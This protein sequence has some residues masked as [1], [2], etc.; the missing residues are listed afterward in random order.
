M[1]N[2]QDA[3]IF[4]YAKHSIFL[5]TGPE[6]LSGSTRLKAGSSQK[7]VLNMISTGVMV[8][9]GKVYDN[10]MVDVQATNTKLVKRAAR[11]VMLITKASQEQAEEAL[12]QSKL[13]VK[14]ACLLILKNLNYQE[15]DKLL[16]EQCGSLRKAINHD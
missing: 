14:H 5:R 13:R 1:S 16:Q 7:T 2:N 11:L 10:L 9:L 4:N 6:L 3:E 15:A 8:K 12:G